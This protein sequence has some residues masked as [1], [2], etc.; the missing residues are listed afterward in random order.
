[1][2]RSLLAFSLGIYVAQEYPAIPRVKTIVNNV[3][4]DINDKLKEYENISKNDKK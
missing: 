3:I 4:K 2:I 1:M